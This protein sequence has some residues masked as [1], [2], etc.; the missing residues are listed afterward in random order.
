MTNTSAD[1]PDSMLVAVY[2]AK[3]EV[4]IEERPVP[5]P[6]SGQVLVE[7]SH[8]GV[9][10]SDIHMML[11]G[12]GKPGTIE[13]HEFTGVIAAI[14]PDVEGWNVGDEIVGGP[15]P[16]CGVCRKCLA[17]LPSQCERRDG[18]ITDASDG[19]FAGYKL[20]DAGALLRVP[21]VLSLR[22]AALAEPLAVALHGI[23]RSAI[24][25]GD[26]AMVLGAGP[27]GALTI[28]VLVAR[29]I[30]PV[31]VVEPG[32]RRRRL[33][34]DLG[35]TEAIEPDALEVFPMWEPERI[36]ERAVD[37]VF[38]CSGRRTAME[39]GFH[40]LHRGGH[41]VLVGAGIEPPT[42]DPNRFILNELRI[43]GSFIYDAEGF[44]DALA[45]LASGA[46]P[47]DRLIDPVDVPLDRLGV[48]LSSLA[49]GA[50]A[51]KAMVVPTLS[52]EPSNQEEKP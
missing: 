2:R 47:T 35:A 39:A 26:S 49:S 17:G 21:E 40:Q 20:V 31:T 30:G 18:A 44:A 11:D 13:G 6:P 24:A 4:I 25:S 46:L 29:G 10:G 7:V 23:T 34:L 32:S 37:V 28:A 22:A 27:I 45:L 51:G 38:E 9:C 50:I 8:C 12:W 3:G 43:S 15:S 19:A 42:F 1:L 14:G 41:L 36:S 33:A 16:R 5:R 48:T 52:T